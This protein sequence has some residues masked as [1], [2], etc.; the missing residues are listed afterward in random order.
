MRDFI[1]HA[2]HTWIW[3]CE[4]RIITPLTPL[5]SR[6]F[7]CFHCKT[8]WKRFVGA[9]LG[10]FS[11][12]LQSCLIASDPQHPAGCPLP[13][14]GSPV[15]VRI[16][17]QTFD[18]NFTPMSYPF[19]I[20]QWCYTYVMLYYGVCFTSMFIVFLSPQYVLGS[21]H[22]FLLCISFDLFPSLHRIKQLY[23]QWKYISLTH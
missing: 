15:E 2:L 20:Y 8:W 18:Y 22:I 3:G 16:R 9:L 23:I 12:H 19:R 4:G 14:P 1:T 11:C 13:L 10:V 6:H 21:Y 7:H 5:T 17:F